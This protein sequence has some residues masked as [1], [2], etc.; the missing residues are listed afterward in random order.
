MWYSSLVAA[1]VI[2][3]QRLR[4]NEAGEPRV[5]KSDKRFRF[6]DGGG[7]DA[8]L[9]LSQPITAGILKGEHVDFHLID[10]AMRRNHYSPYRKCASI[11][12]L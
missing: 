2:Q 11:K 3:Q 10:K 7:H 12:W 1:D 5:A 8:T 6:G 4:Y 9:A